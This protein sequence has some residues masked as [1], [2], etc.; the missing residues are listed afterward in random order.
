M[1]SFLVLAEESHFGR[2]A[3]RLNIVQPAL[4]MQMRS[5]EEEL[6]GP[7]FIR[8]SRKVELTEAGK[9]LRMEAQR[10]VDHADHARQAV[11]R[12]LRGELGRVRVG[13][14]GNTALSSKLSHDL[15][16]FNTTFP[17]VELIAREATPQSQIDAIQ[18]GELDIGY[19]PDTGIMVPSTLHAE[20]IGQW[21]FVAAVGD[22]HPLAEVP[23]LTAEMVA[24]HAMVLYATSPADDT[25]LSAFR[26]V[27]GRDPTVG[28]RAATT[29]GVLALVA[30]GLGVALVPKST[31]TLAF[32]HVCYKPLCNVQLSA[33]LLIV[34]RTGETNG[35]VNAF[36]A[37]ARRHP[38]VEG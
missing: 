22:S 1:R 12:A 29:L 37:L 30:A 33:R 32:P 8:T 17:D 7:L 5:L 19:L 14:A 2:A 16:G 15:R 27:L 21:C 34:S 10:V 13:F 6:G 35:A 38:M 4:S 18:T 31:T 3:Q 11:S 24:E 25:L 9:L 20:E 26:S 28:Y 23:S 36:L